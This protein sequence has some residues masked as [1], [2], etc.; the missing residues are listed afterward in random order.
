MT[1]TYENSVTA[2]KKKVSGIDINSQTIMT[3]LKYAMEI[4]EKTNLKGDD[5][6]ELVK[7]IVR[8]IVVDA[9]ISDVDEKLLLDIIDQNI[10]DK[11]MELVV[12]AVHGK[13]EINE[14]AELVN[15]CCVSW[16]PRIVDSYKRNT[17]KS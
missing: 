11:I 17:R 15:T 12:D 14:A 16:V 8:K 10:I 2:L 13:L 4:V 3:V 9:P 5:K 7:T 1:S 6:K